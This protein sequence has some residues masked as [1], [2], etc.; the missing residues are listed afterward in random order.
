MPKDVTLNFRPNTLRV[1]FLF[2]P[3]EHVDKILM[4]PNQIRNSRLMTS[5]WLTD[6]DHDNSPNRL[7]HWIFIWIIRY[8]FYEG[9]LTKSKIL[10]KTT[11]L[12]VF[13]HCLQRNASIEKNEI[14]KIGWE[15]VSGFSLHYSP[16]TQK[17]RTATK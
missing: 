4:M 17:P 5:R 2:L 9:D 13:D 3:Y 11:Y 10:F 7:Q 6:Q 14:E 8:V 1:D 12:N 15:I 16:K